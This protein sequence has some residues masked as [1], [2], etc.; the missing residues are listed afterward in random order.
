MNRIF[1]LIFE[2]GSIEFVYLSILCISI[3][4]SVGL[5]SPDCVV[6]GGRFLFQV[7]NLF[8]WGIKSTGGNG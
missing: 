5:A 6:R 1:E 3:L 7:E 2:I 4:A 8:D